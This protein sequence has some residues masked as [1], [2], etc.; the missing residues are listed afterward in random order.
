MFKIVRKVSSP[1]KAEPKRCLKYIC[2]YIYI[3]IYRCIRCY[4]CWVYYILVHFFRDPFNLSQAVQDNL[5]LWASERLLP[6]TRATTSLTRCEL[7]LW[8]EPA[9][10]LNDDN[11][12]GAEQTKTGNAILV[13]Q[14]SV[15]LYS[16]IIWNTNASTC[17]VDC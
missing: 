1:K 10:H 8:D 12:S 15:D 9:R 13:G 14:F 5:R 2:T 3:Y 4:S 17:V 7:E 11:L 16:E 6:A